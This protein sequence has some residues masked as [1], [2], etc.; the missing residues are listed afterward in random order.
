MATASLQ[1]Q[2][3]EVESIDILKKLVE[4]NTEL[5]RQIQNLTE[6]ING[7]MLPASG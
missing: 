6:Q 3:L 5:T 2:Q 7:R 4:E 1:R